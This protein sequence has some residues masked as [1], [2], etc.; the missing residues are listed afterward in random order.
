MSQTRI[1]TQPTGVSAVLSGGLNVKTRYVV[2]LTAFSQILAYVNGGTI[3]STLD[4]LNQSVN[5]LID[6]PIVFP[7]ELTPY[8]TGESGQIPIN[9][10]KKTI[11]GAYSP[12]LTG[13][14]QLIA[15]Y[16][17]DT[18]NGANENFLDFEPYT[19]YRLFL[20]F[21][22]EVPLSF[23]D[24][25]GAIIN[26]K[27]YC[28]FDTGLATVYVV[29]TRNG[30]SNTIYST[31]LQLG[32]QL[33]LSIDSQNSSRLR[34]AIGTVM[35]GALAIA[36][37]GAAVPA[38][39][40]KTTEKGIE[41]YSRGADRGARLKLSGRS[42]E[43]TQ[44]TTTH[45][46]G[47]S[48]RAN[49]VAGTINGVQ[50]VMLQ[51]GAAASVGGVNGS[52][53]SFATYNKPYIKIVHPRIV[54]VTNYGHYNGYACMEETSLG[55]HTGYCEVYSVHLEGFGGATAEELA[56]IERLLKSGVIL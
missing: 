12:T 16:E 11:Q 50:D 38:L 5:S 35:K 36:T 10:G 43:Y 13:A 30:I 51:Q 19:E 9:I 39:T 34:A 32:V 18:L 52:L 25:Q 41:Q 4:N 47:V 17:S 55:D 37:S 6:N 2:D 46:G 40:T 26:V 1:S 3:D 29:A 49:I 8:S 15:Q 53:S 20:P 56:Q 22:G 42:T 7:F 28:D 33:S 27:Y 31:Q 24:V 14:Y 48:T 44:E 23:K 54:D 21:V 45:E